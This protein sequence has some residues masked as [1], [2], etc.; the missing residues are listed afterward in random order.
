M[1]DSQ[2]TPAYRPVDLQQDQFNLLGLATRAGLLVS[3]FSAV[4]KALNRR[5]LSMLILDDD[6]GKHTREKLM[7]KAQKTGAKVLV[8]KKLTLQGW[9]GNKVVG[10]LTGELAKRFEET[11]KQEY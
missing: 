6:T 2:D 3:G 5:S 9:S 7:S 10:L 4:D 11:L 1:A 8:L